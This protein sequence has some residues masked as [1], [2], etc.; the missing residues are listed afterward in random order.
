MDYFDIFNSMVST[1]M[2]GKIFR[3]ESDTPQVDEDIAEQWQKYEDELAE[4]PNDSLFE[5]L[6]PETAEEWWDSVNMTMPTYQNVNESSSDGDKR[7]W[8]VKGQSSFDTRGKCATRLK[9]KAVIRIDKPSD[10][11]YVRK[12]FSAE[13]VP[14]LYVPLG[15]TIT[16]THEPQDTAGALNTSF[17]ESETVGNDRAGVDQVSWKFND[18]GL[19]QAVTNVMKAERPELFDEAMIENMTL[20]EYPSWWEDVVTTYQKTTARVLEGNYTT[21]FNQ[22]GMIRQRGGASA[23][24]K[25]YDTLGKYR[26]DI[27]YGYDWEAEVESQKNSGELLEGK[28]FFTQVGYRFVQVAYVVSVIATFFV[29]S[30]AW[31]KLG[32]KLAF[33][34]GNLGRKA[35]MLAVAG[36]ELLAIDYMALELPYRVVQVDITHNHNQCGFPPN[37]HYHSYWVNVYDPALTDS[38]GVPHCAEGEHKPILVQEPLKYDKEIP[39]CPDGT[40]F[41]TTQKACIG[42]DADGNDIVALT[43]AGIVPTEVIPKEEISGLQT[44]AFIALGIAGVVILTTVFGSKGNQ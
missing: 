2:T 35:F 14:T 7:L 44:G 25:T 17:V 42:K 33:W 43:G 41:D 22:T 32:G 1:N 29:G 4:T 24:S 10:M 30:A 5:K 9:S 18:T 34:A 15:T 11:K 37:G 28:S 16:Y 12:G 31:S 40:T 23:S 20:D 3:E 13:G 6:I 8:G 36:I 21:Y 39:C 26:Q 19:D 27:I 38:Y